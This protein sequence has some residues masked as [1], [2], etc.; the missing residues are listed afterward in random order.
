MRQDRTGQPPHFLSQLY[1]HLHC[2]DLCISHFHFS[3][4]T[5]CFQGQHFSKDGGTRKIEYNEPQSHLSIESKYLQ[6]ASVVL[7]EL[8]WREIVEE[9]GYNLVCLHT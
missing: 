9:E 2:F 1:A 7:R 8:A 3:S 6:K 5:D 4:L